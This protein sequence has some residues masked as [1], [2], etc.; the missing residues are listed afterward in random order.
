M[1]PRIAAVLRGDGLPPGVGEEAC[2]AS[3]DCLGEY[4]ARYRRAVGACARMRM[5]ASEYAL[6][7]WEE[8]RNSVR[9]DR[10]FRAGTE[11]LA[12]EAD[13]LWIVDYKTT[14]HGREGVEEFLAEERAKYGPQ[15]EAYARMMRSVGGREA[16]RGAVLS[17]VAEV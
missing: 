11:P 5:H 4:V 7:S 15:M 2:C 10:V 12:E 3:A 16:S 9:L 14:T 17:D 8:R 6:T 13:C 1:G